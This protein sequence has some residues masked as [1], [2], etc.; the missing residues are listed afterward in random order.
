MSDLSRRRRVVYITGDFF[1]DSTWVE[2]SVEARYVAIGLWSLCDADG[3]FAWQPSQI[4]AMLAVEDVAP[5]LAELTDLG[6]V[7]RLGEAGR[8]APL[9]RTL[10]VTGHFVGPR[11]VGS[12][13]Q[14]TRERIIARDGERCCYCGQPAAILEIDHVIPVARGG[15]SDDGNL[16]VACKPC[17]RAKGTKLLTEWTP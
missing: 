6:L 16:A 8:V 7:E 13:W 2:A 1:R 12:N 10:R 17:N 15:G 3:V 9:N 5:I 14:A 4:S 11:P